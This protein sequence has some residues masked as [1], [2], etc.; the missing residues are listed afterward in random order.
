MRIRSIALLLLLTFLTGPADT[1][2]LRKSAINDEAL[3]L[4][5]EEASHFVSLALKCVTKEYPNK[6]D[7][8]MND[9]SEV[10][11][12][13]ALH[14]AFY[15]CLDWHSSVHG[16][17][18]LARVLKLFPDLPEAQKIRSTLDGNLSASNIQAEVSYLTQANRQSFERTY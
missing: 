16:H 14:P 10:R 13:R 11:G 18:M 3:K 2:A 7:H 9:A 4:T 8:T 12:P 15:G 17:W 6:L 5:R 1:S